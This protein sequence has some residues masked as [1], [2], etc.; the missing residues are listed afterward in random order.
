MAPLAHVDERFAFPLRRMALIGYFFPQI[1]AWEKFHII[2]IIWNYTVL[3]ASNID[4]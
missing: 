1:A 2:I 3:A 4:I